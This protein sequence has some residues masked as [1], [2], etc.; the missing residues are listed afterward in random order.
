MSLSSK[1]KFFTACFYSLLSNIK[2]SQTTSEVTDDEELI[3]KKVR[4]LSFLLSAKA[5]NDDTESSLKDSDESTEGGDL[6]S[7]FSSE[8]YI[9]SLNFLLSNMIIT[10]EEG[11]A[12][13]VDLHLL[14]TLLLLLRVPSSASCPSDVLLQASTQ[15]LRKILWI[16][17]TTKLPFKSLYLSLAIA[18]EITSAVGWEWT[19]LPDNEALDFVVLT[20]FP[21]SVTSN[22]N[23]KLFETIIQRAG[24][25]IDLG[26]REVVT[27]WEVASAPPPTKTPSQI[28]EV[29][30]VVPVE[31]DK[32]TTEEKTGTLLLSYLILRSSLDF[33]VRQLELEDE[34]TSA[35]L[36]PTT[37]NIPTPVLL[38]IYEMT[39]KYSETSIS[40][41]M[42]T[43]KR[44]NK[45]TGNFVNLL[46]TESS[47]PVLISCV[48][49]VTKFIY[50]SLDDTSI[51]KLV[52]FLPFLAELSEIYPEIEGVLVECILCLLKTDE[53]LA[54]EIVDMKIKQKLHPGKENKRLVVKLAE[55][56]KHPVRSTRPLSLIPYQDPSI[57]GIAT[58][59]AML[60]HHSTNNKWLLDDSPL[61]LSLSAFF[62]DRLELLRRL[63]SGGTAEIPVEDID[64]IGYLSYV[65]LEAISGSFSASSFIRD[66][67]SLL[68]HLTAG[69]EMVFKFCVKDF[70]EIQD[71]SLICWILEVCTN[72]CMEIPSM[73]VILRPLAN[74]LP[75]N[76]SNM[77]LMNFLRS[78][79]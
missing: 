59:M 33:A 66:S 1:K 9:P 52:E 22:I 56:A 47:V 23:T 55:I 74:T 51:K 64:T 65:L 15:K 37:G 32:A 38:K 63:P 60:V 39:K 25:E 76:T 73:S 40:F 13:L 36:P 26:L 24:I 42:V 50:E 20:P 16:L 68:G 61:I 35:R 44:Y 67:E 79:N 57:A 28:T 41:I 48:S 49:F 14:E 21:S 43:F 19:L 72:I 71:D 45:L 31:L 62:V 10:S 5:V 54:R 30:D 8:L 70:E 78:L 69:L 58:V 29:E 11:K 12:N 4:F 27:S 77:H 17:F 53:S 3:P 34:D 46:D 7:S 2:N 18:N 6:S 75:K